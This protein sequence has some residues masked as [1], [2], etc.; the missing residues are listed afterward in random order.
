MIRRLRD[1]G[2]WLERCRHPE[3]DPPSMMYLP[4]GLYEHQCPG[5]GSRTRFTGSRVTMLALVV[6][7]VL[8]A[9]GGGARCMPAA[10]G[11]GG[12]GGP[13]KPCEVRR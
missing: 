9:C 13:A 1:A 10:P 3:H 6:A 5:C 12:N 8:S 4:A 11:A 2:Q 7:L